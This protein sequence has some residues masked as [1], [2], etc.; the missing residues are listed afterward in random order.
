MHINQARVIDFLSRPDAHRGQSVQRID[1]HAS[2]VF[3]AGDRAWK[4]KRA[5]RYPY[6]DFSKLERRKASCEAELATNRRTAPDLYLAVV[7]V[8][9]GPDGTMAI[10]GEGEPVEWLL[11]MVQFDQDRLLDRLAS[12]GELE[13]ALMVPLAD[14]IANLHLEAEPRP[15]FGGRDGMQW[16]VDGNA[17]DLTGLDEAE[18]TVRD[19]LVE[20]S[21][22][23]LDR[24]AALLDVRGR[25]GWVRQCHGDLHLRNIVLLEQ[26]PTLFDAVEFNDR[27]S[28]VDVLYDLAFLL[29]DL[30]RRKLPHHANG[31]WNRYLTRIP[32]RSGIPALPLFLSCRAAVRAKTS[33]AA[34]RLQTDELKVRELRETVRTYLDLALTL[35]RARGPFLLAVGGLSGSGKSSLAYELAPD[36]G[37]VPGAVVLRSDEIR[38]ALAG[39]P[40]HSTLTQ[41]GYSES[42]TRQVYRELSDRATAVLRAGHGVIADAVFARSDDRE[43]IAHTADQL[44]VPFAGLWLEAPEDVLVDRVSARRGD[45]SDADAA[46]VRRR[47]ARSLGQMTWHRIDASTG[48]P[49]VAACAR[50]AL[51]IR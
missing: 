36:V 13:R 49:A 38:K 6:L 24:Q 27:I 17:A 11:E 18:S 31:V 46:V 47:L 8:T 42:M 28:C 51:R 30:W 16:V 10:D 29:M 4:L 35:L 41:E 5:V 19:A 44:S 20:E 12:R 32:D 23:A 50:E 33:L 2:V 26:G 7:P 37:P 15:E 48:L 9:V 40:A 14:A 34:A 1:T 25:D 43:A 45:A 3:L 22:R 39:V 21:R